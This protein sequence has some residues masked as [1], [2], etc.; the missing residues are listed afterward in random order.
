MRR[1]FHC[2]QCRRP[3]RGI[4][5]SATRLDM[6]CDACGYGFRVVG[7]RIVGDAL[8]HSRR[9]VAPASNTTWAIMAA[10]LTTALI[11]FVMGYLEK[12]V[13][14]ALFAAIVGGI[15]AGL[16]TKWQRGTQV[17]VRYLTAE[18]RAAFATTRQLEDARDK[19]MQSRNGHSLARRKKLDL[20]TRLVALRRKMRALALPAYAPRIASIDSA[21]V[22]LDRQIDMDRRLC[23][24]YDRSIG[25]IEVEL[26]AGAAV[27]QMD[28]NIS[29][30]IEESMRELRELE[31]SQAE[32]E[33]QLSANIEVE[34]LLK[35]A[36]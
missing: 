25:M 27:D 17:P 18:R 2:P 22:M 24:G 8:V 3:L 29:E 19:L 4:P 34:E 26:E 13:S 23:A 10:L 30:A 15:L 9:I 28:A 16:S 7:G 21:L 31:D 12:P 20:R 6:S 36:G 32:L 11:A 1:V 5:S 35:R 14:N 33:R